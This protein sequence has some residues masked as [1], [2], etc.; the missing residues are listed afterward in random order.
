ME[1]VISIQNKKEI[2]SW[3]LLVYSMQERQVER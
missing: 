1:N 2:K 3:N